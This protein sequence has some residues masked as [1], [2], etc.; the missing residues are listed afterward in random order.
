ARQHHRDG[1][2][3]QDPALRRRARRGARLLRG[4]RRCRL[5]GRRRAR[6][7]V[8]RRRHRVP[9]RGPAADRRRPRRPVRDGLRPAAEHQPGAG[10]VLPGRRDAAGPPGPL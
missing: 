1:Q 4:A 6:R 9:R 5:V 8:R 10:A 7:A 2:R 3:L